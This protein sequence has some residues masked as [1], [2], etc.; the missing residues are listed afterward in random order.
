M[1]ADNTPKPSLSGLHYAYMQKLDEA[2]SI[3]T[4]PIAEHRH[5]MAQLIN[6]LEEAP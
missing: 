1:T 5:V 6:A 2:L 3:I 4:E